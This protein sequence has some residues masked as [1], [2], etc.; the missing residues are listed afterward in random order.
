MKMNPTKLIKDKAK[1]LSS[2]L[3]IMLLL[4]LS[5]SLYRSISRIDTVNLGIEAVQKRVDKLK[6]ENQ[7]LETKLREVRDIEF[8]E[9]QLR[10]KLG[11]AKEGEIVIVLPED[12]VLRKLAPEIQEE[13][14]VLP[15]PNW[16][17]WMQL[18]DL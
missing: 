8:V 14:E 4:A 6:E 12:E 5:L 11:L 7:R 18:F 2:F 1:K 9:K 10:D 3:L 16:E 17:K 13:E 15:D